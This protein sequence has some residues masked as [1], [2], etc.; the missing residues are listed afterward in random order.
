MKIEI[1]KKHLY[2]LS[3]VLVLGLAGFLVIAIDVSPPRHFL[4]SIAKGPGPTDLE[5]VDS[6]LDGIIDLANTFVGLPLNQDS[7]SDGII[8]NATNS[9]KVDGLNAAD[10]VAQGAGTV[11]ETFYGINACPTG[12][13]LAVSGVAYGVRAEVYPGPG[14]YSASDFLICAGGARVTH[15]QLQSE[16]GIGIIKRHHGSWHFGPKLYAWGEDFANGVPYI[17]CVVCYK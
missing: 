16:Q 14:T 1:N 6:N 11:V 2:I 13:S 5:S 4:Q 7:D 17:R 3:I 10:L 15:T 9:D 12:W 8:D